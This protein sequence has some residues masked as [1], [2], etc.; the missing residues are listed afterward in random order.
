MLQIGATAMRWSA[1]SAIAL[2]Q[3]SY[4][5]LKKFRWGSAWHE[6]KLFSLTL[7]LATVAGLIWLHDKDEFFVYRED[8]QFHNLTY[9]SADELYEASDVDGWSTFWLRKESILKAILMHPY[10][11]SAEISIALPANVNITVT[12]TEPIA[13]WV[14]DAGTLWLLEDGQAVTARHTRTDG[15][16]QILDERAAARKVSFDPVVA[17]E[18][19]VLANVR[20]L[21]SYYPELKTVSYHE[22]VGLNFAPP[23]GGIWVYWGDG[24]QF[25]KKLA[26]LLTIQNELA[27]GR[28]NGQLAD[29]RLPDK[30]IVR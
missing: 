2:C 22:G 8:V 12:E 9:L 15:L 19:D 20:K 18:P 25:E 17:I 7:L 28:L 26:N 21:I 4:T 6:S 27:Q 5:N 30:P 24:D 10:V 29:L 13:L 1:G 23:F 11:T 14:T 16:L 3:E